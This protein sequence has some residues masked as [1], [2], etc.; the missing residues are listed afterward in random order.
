[1][2]RSANS[3]VG[4]LHR[5]LLTYG[6]VRSS[7]AA[8]RNLT[9]HGVCVWASDSLRTGM[10]QWS[11]R[12]SGF[13]RYPSPYA[14]EDG[15]VRAVADACVRHG[16]GLVFPSHNET[17]TLAR[18]RAELPPGTDRLLPNAEHCALFNNKSASYELAASLGLD[19]PRRLVYRDPSE[20]PAIVRELERGRGVVIKLLTSNS[21]KGVFYA[22]DP[23]S[24]ARTVSELIER[25][26]LAPE[27]YPQIEERITGEG[28]GCSVLYWDGRAIASF[29]H[30]RLR[31][32]IAT[33]GTST[34]RESIA[35]PAMEEAARRIFE[36]VGW[37][38]LA[39]AEFKLCPESGRAWFIEV[40]PRMWGSIPLAVSAGA[41]F[42]FLLWT[43]AAH[44]PDA[45]AE[46]HRR[47]APRIGWTGRWLLGDC[48]V[49]ASQMAKLHPVEAMR[50]LFGTRADSWDDLRWDDPMAF[51]GEIAHYGTQFLATRS[52]NPAEKGSV[53]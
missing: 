37:H 53:G 39:M 29:C 48:I 15:F 45:A 47:T 5:V 21:A 6:W 41:E 28:A 34:L 25:F 10:C 31:E 17:E 33:G 4:P 43:C 42:P 20:V 19:V 14:D 26:E 50:T 30:R 1:M 38:G 51:L 16:I 18:R 8:L 40:N 52:T 46:L 9:D 11:R 3:D 22:S 7:Y 35:S 12:R 13:V 23:E 24:A 49:A 32:K 44:G 36:H 2:K 27:R